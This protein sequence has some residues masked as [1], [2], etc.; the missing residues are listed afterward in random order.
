MFHI[1]TPR[2]FFIAALCFV[3]FSCVNRKKIVYFQ[4]DVPVKSD[5]LKLNSPKLQSDDLLSITVMG[6]DAEAVKPFNLSTYG[7][8]YGK[9]V[10]AGQGDPALAGYLIDSK[11]EIDF[12]VIGKLKLTG[13]NR[14][15]AAIYISSK[16]K[17]YVKDPMVNLRIMNFKITILGDVARPA[18]YTI[19]NE[20]ITLIEA[21]G[22]AGDLNL[23]GKRKNVLVI[24]DMDGKKTETRV[25][26][27]NNEVFNSAV[28]YLK[29]NDVIYVE[30]NRA[31]RNAAGVNLATVSV[32]VSLTSIVITLIS[33]LTRK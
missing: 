11:G 22:L 28:Y 33:I 25:D 20:R 6:L 18:T 8:Y 30:H 10:N 3:C 16:L 32:L 5:T 1:F 17:D 24:R 23:S 19:P 26:L 29:Q 9:E 27:T 21:I 4:G 2:N 7:S 31:K 15:E 14:S 12:P 13:L